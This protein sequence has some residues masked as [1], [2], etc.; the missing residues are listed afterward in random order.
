MSAG[1][2]Q[3]EPPGI[4][5]IISMP[6]ERMLVAAWTTLSWGGRPMKVGA[7]NNLTGE[8]VAIKRGSV[9]GEVTVKLKLSAAASMSSVMTLSSIDEMKL[10]EGDKVRV[11]A[12]AVNVLLIKE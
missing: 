5:N 3:P 12:K 1:V 8:V 9:M 10:K 11:V 7:R 4:C 2:L 6:G